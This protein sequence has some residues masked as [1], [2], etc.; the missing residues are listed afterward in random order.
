MRHDSVWRRFFW[1]VQQRGDERRN[2]VNGTERRGAGHM[3]ALVLWFIAVVAGVRAFAV[4][5]TIAAG[6]DV[7]GGVIG[8]DV[9][10]GVDD[11]APAPG[12]GD[13]GVVDGDGDGIEGTGGVDDAG[14][15]VGEGAGGDDLG[16]EDFEGWRVGVLTLTLVVVCGGA[17]AGVKTWGWGAGDVLSVTTVGAD[18]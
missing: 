5:V 6:G 16:T 7:G 10:I 9:G 13:G 1:F 3:G 8:V 11:T 18:C 4:A 15:I 17:G 2:F 12:V 14:V